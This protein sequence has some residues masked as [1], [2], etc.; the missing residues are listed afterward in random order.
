MYRICCLLLLAAL[1]ACS[2]SDENPRP[3]LVYQP[4][5]FPA[6]TYDLTANPPTESGFELGRKLFY[7]VRLSRTATISCGSCH[8][9]PAAFA[10]S[11]HDVSHGVDDLNGTRNAPVLVNLAW[12]RFFFWDGGVFNL[13]LL[14]LVPLQHPREMDAS[15][16]EVLQVLRKDPDYSRLFHAGFGDTSVTLPRMLQAM[17]QFMVSLVSADS[18]YDQALAGKGPALSE[19]EKAGQA[20]FTQ[21]CV[22]CHA[23]PL[24]T[25]GLFH[26][27]GLTPTGINDRG[28]YA[29]TLNEADAYRFKTPTLRNIAVSAPYMHDGRFRSLEAVLRH[30]AQ[31]VQDSPTLDTVLR[32][33]GRTGIPLSPEEQNQLIAFL[34][35][36]T[37]EN[38]IHDKKFREE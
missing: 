16:P 13:D 27:N 31:G 19:A 6:A 33:E 15:L 36:L 25:D 29:I 17:S 22:S 24:F 12:N 30:Y 2:P 23:P 37:D 32:K 11:G 20:L 4:P 14:P 18:R 5:G 34:K 1:A 26:N 21:H 10:H 35:T 38:F 7:D 9:L 8:Q 28:R 3:A